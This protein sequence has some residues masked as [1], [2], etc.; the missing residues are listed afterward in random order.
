[1]SGY[2]NQDWETFPV[3]QLKGVDHPTT[4]IDADKV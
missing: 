3:K 4:R 1:M 2:H